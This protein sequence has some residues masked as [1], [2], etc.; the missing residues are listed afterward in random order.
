VNEISRRRT[1]T[2]CTAGQGMARRGGAW[3]GMARRGTDFS[4][5]SE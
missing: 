1:A 3:L 5:I 4:K 2:R